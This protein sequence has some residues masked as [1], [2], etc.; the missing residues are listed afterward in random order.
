MK[1]LIR[2]LAVLALTLV[3]GVL[4]T[5]VAQSNKGSVTGHVKDTSGAILQGAQVEMQ[6]SGVTVATNDQG[7]YFI[8]DL[9][10]GTYTITITYVGFSLFTQV[11]N[12]TAGHAE[13]VDA[14]MAVSSQNDQILVTAARVSGEAEAIN[15]ERT[16]DNIVQVLPNEVFTSLPNA[17]SPTP[18]ADCRASP[19]NGTKARESTFR[20][21]P[22][23]PALPTPLLTA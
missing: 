14:K 18:L 3:C 1:R 9:T 12:V 11:V 10:P 22:W 23:S 8:N 17:M 16:A 20:C 5:A 15:R 21:A 6:P 13:T 19:S 7:A 2:L 4:Q